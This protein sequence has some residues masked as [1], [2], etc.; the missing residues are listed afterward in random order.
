MLTEVATNIY[1]FTV[2]YP[3]DMRETNCY[4]FKGTKGFTVVDTGS[5]DA[6]AIK[7]W[8]RLFKSGITVEK[9]V[10]TH[11]HPDHVGLAH[12]FQTRCHVP[13]LLSEQGAEKIQRSRGLDNGAWLNELFRAH[14]GPQMS[15]ELLKLESPD[16]DFEPDGLFQDHQ[17]IT[18]GQ[19][20]YEAI[21]TPGHAS[22]H[23]CF[24]NGETRILVA[25]DL[26]LAHLSPIVGIWE[27]G[28]ETALADY[29]KSLIKVKQKAVHLALPG[30]G[31]LITDMNSRVD[32][33]RAKHNYRLQQ[34]LNAVRSD[35]KNAM[36]ICEII[37]GKLTEQYLFAP[38]MSIIARCAYL[39]SCRKLAHVVKRGVTYYG[40]T[41]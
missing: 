17:L 6:E 38:F 40:A 28:D 25:G 34:V 18:L 22:D 7:D 8:E 4:L 32:A 5:R 26:V 23:F 29:F 21:W 36:Q 15:A 13:V 33:I 35:E 1:Q 39:E 12:W 27:A 10:F 2:H 37:Y 19:S 9:V 30:H 31:D 24:Y 3:F 11:T 16:N 14:G 41:L 20:D